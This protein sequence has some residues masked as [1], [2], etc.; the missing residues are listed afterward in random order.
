MNRSIGSVFLGGVHPQGA[1]IVNTR[2]IKQRP[3]SFS[4]LILS[5]D[6]YCIYQ[7][8]PQQFKAIDWSRIPFYSYSQTEKEVS[9]IS[10]ANLFDRPTQMQAGWRRLHINGTIPLNQPGILNTILS[11][12]AK[13][14]ISVLVVSTFDTDYVFF[15]ESDMDLTMKSLQNCGFQIC[16]DSETNRQITADLR[17]CML[18]LRKNA[19]ERGKKE[20]IDTSSIIMTE[21]RK[22]FLDGQ[23]VDRLVIFL[24]GTGCTSTKKSGGC[25]F[26][27]F[28]NATNFNEKITDADYLDQ[29]EKAMRQQKKQFPII[30]IY[31]DGSLFATS[32]KL[33]ALRAMSVREMKYFLATI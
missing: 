25:T 32:Q 19:A 20:K 27:G 5:P 10:L 14:G 33:M 18:Q 28:Y 13:N 1:S 12:L 9:V 30:C 4:T 15:K 2:K 3:P 8:S 29:F 26:C 17:T 11:P 31:N 22:G 24:K 16:G 7:F 6:P 23:M 21:I